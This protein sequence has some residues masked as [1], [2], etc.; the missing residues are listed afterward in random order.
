M[1]ERIDTFIIWPHGLKNKNE[2]IGVISEDFNVLYIK[3]INVK[4]MRRF[5]K[6]VYNFDYA[7]IIHLKNKTKYLETVGCDVM[8][9]VVRNINPELEF[10]DVGKFRHIECAKIKLKKLQIRQ[11]FNPVVDGH[12]SEEHVVHASDNEQQ[13][14]DIMRLFKVPK[15]INISSQSGT[16][17]IN[18]GC[19]YQLKY[20]KLD[21]IYCFNFEQSGSKIARVEKELVNSVQYDFIVGDKSKYQDYLDKFL[22]LYLHDLYSLSKFEK[23]ILEFD[24]KRCPPIVIKEDAKGRY[25]ILDGLHRATMIKS[26]GMNEI[27]AVVIR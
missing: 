7:P 21:D 1:K 19:A 27:K 12:L 18:K 23:F 8:C 16:Y 24:I 26:L 3:Q 10:F 14:W 5:V 4:S 25:Y 11:K 22:G 13:S 17:H 9:I 15:E 2:I 6:E 20:I